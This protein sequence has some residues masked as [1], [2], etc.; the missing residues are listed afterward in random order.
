VTYMPSQNDDT[1]PS[2]KRLR[3]ID[4]CVYVLHSTCCSP[5]AQAVTEENF[6]IFQASTNLQ[7]IPSEFLAFNVCDNK[8]DTLTQSQMLKDSDRDQIISSQAAEVNGLNKM[9][10]FEVLLMHTKPAQAKLLNAIWSYPQK[11]SPV[12]T[13]LKH[14]ARLCVDGSQQL[15]GRDFWETYAP[16]I[17]WSSIRLMLLLTSVHN[18]HSCQV[19]Y[20]QAFPQAP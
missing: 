20:T 2:Y 10:V 19:D 12:G 1:F 3:L 13:I 4:T 6:S 8:A 9:E 17:S 15:Q 5:S 14:K 7:P 11:R 18:L 16:V